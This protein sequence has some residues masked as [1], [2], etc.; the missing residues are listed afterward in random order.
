MSANQTTNN[1]DTNTPNSPH[2]DRCDLNISRKVQHAISGILFAAACNYKYEIFQLVASLLVIAT[3]IVEILRRIEEFQWVNDIIILFCGSTLRQ[4]EMVFR[5]SGSRVNVT[6]AIDK[7]TGSF[8][9]FLGSWM[10]SMVFS[11]VP[12]TFGILML[13]IADP[14]ASYFGLRTRHIQTLR[15]GGKGVLGIIGGTLACLPFN[16]V[17]LSCAD[18]PFLAGRQTIV[19]IVSLMIGLFASVADFIV[20]S[21]PYVLVRSFSFGIIEIPA[22]HLDDN[23]VIPIISAAACKLI[24]SSL[25][26]NPDDHKLLSF[27]IY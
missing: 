19:V 24:I 9:F 15:I 3:Y 7:M 10:T 21:P 18:W 23:V 4:D 25:G 17:I 1:P 2:R 6:G 26:W 5:K 16:Y 13:G 11:A 27:L 20:Q 14:A 22:L 12:A 8:Y